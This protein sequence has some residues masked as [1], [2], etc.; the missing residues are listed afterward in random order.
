M[1]D[2]REPDQSKAYLTSSRVNT[3]FV[4]FSAVVAVVN[5][6]AHLTYQSLAASLSDSTVYV[7]IAGVLLFS[8]IHRRGH[9]IRAVTQILFI[10]MV[11]VVAI[12]DTVDSVFGLGFA[13]LGSYL[14]FRYDLFEK[15]RLMKIG[16]IVI[17]LTMAI[18]LSAWLSGGWPGAIT[19]LAF[20][21]FFSTILL[22][23]ELDWI[24]RFRTARNEAEQAM[25]MVGSQIDLIEVGLTKREI[26]VAL[27]LVT[28]KATDKEVAYN[29]NI[30]VDTVRNH[31]KNMRRKLKVPSKIELIE[32]CRWYVTTH[33]TH[34]QMPEHTTSLDSKSNSQ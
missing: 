6:I 17:L 18:V 34:I 14:M 5:L 30:S 2:P 24:T 7:P 26:Q 1:T 31:L 16:A 21:V 23:A 27:Q 13:I 4:L 33:E 25:Q 32:A 28:T 3:I 19:T 12:F 22:F 15:R 9:I 20:M 8:I 29:L 10:Y 11:S